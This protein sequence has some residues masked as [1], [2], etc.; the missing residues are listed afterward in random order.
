[1]LLSKCIIL[2]C[3]SRSQR[4]CS[5]RTTPIWPPKLF[6][7]KGLQMYEFLYPQSPEVR[8]CEPVI[9]STN[10]NKSGTAFEHSQFNEMGC[11]FIQA[12]NISC[13]SAKA[14]NGLAKLPK[15]KVRLCICFRYTMRGRLAKNMRPME[16]Q[17]QNCDKVEKREPEPSCWRWY[18]KAVTSCSDP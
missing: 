1:M 17:A 18:C 3:A 16:Q 7:S 12:C 2:I 13:H 15:V 10:H 6:L 14:Y 11:S 5:V 4:Q 8:Q 9:S